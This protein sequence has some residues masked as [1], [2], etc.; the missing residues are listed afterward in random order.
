MYTLATIV[1]SLVVRAKTEDLGVPVTTDEMPELRGLA[2]AV[3]HRLNNRPVDAIFLTPGAEIGV[4]ER[5]SL[6]RTM[7][8][9]QGQRGLIVGM[10]ALSG[11]TLGHLRAIFAHEYGHFNQRGTVGGDFVRLVQRSLNRIAIN[12][13]CAGLAIWITRPGSSSTYS[14]VF[15][16]A[17][18]WGLHAYRRSWPTARLPWLT[19]PPT[20][21]AASSSSSAKI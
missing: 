5:G 21:P 16:C 14:T 12:L 2:R 3:A 10:G 8:R 18:P 15:S 4:L 19:E 9:D 7:V 6:L 1:L 17:S 11:L 20:W 13:A